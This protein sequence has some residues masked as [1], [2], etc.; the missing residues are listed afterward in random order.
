MNHM[1]DCYGV[2]APGEFDDDYFRD[3]DDEA[4]YA[5]DYNDRQKAENV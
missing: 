4:N 1:I 5:D 3:P 2:L